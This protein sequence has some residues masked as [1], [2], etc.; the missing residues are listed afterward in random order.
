MTIRRKMTV[1]R[2]VQ[3]GSTRLYQVGILPDGTLVNPNNYPE[4]IV[5]TAVL[6]ADARKHERRSSAAR[7]AAVTRHD[8]KQKRVWTAANYIREKQDIHTS[9]HCWIC[10]RY[11]DDPESINR[12]IGPE[13]WQDVLT[14]MQQLCSTAD[15]KFPTDIG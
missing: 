8:R 15:Q 12:G 1:Y 11:L 7:K 2:W 5:R 14:Q 13:C 4:D 3:H 6:A 9:G 10:G